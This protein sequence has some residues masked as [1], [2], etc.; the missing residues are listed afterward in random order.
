MKLI[1][2][3]TNQERY[4]IKRMNGQVM[5]ILESEMQVDTG[6]GFESPE[7]DN[8]WILDH[9][10]ISV[11]RKCIFF[12]GDYCVAVFEPFG[13]LTPSDGYYWITE[14]DLSVNKTDE[15]AALLL[16]KNADQSK[17]APWMS[18]NGLFKYL[19]WAKMSL[20]EMGYTVQGKV[21][22]IKN[23]YI[24]TIFRIPTNVSVVYLKI[25]SSVYVNNANEERQLTERFGELP[26]FLAVSPDGFAA[27]TK[28]MPGHDCSIGSTEQYERWLVSWGKKQGRTAGGNT[29]G[30]IDCSPQKLL[31]DIFD[32]EQQ[33]THILEVTKRPLSELGHKLL[34]EKLAQI[35]ISLD[36]LCHHT[37]PNT[38][39]HVDI[40]SGNVRITEDS[41][42]LYDWGMAFYGHPF[43]DLLHFLRV[44][45]RQLTEEQK[46][47][48]IDAYLS[49]W[50]PYGDKQMLQELY[51]QTE[52]CMEYFM[53]TADCRWVAEILDVC[54]GIPPKGTLDSWLLGKRL[55]YFDR[56]LHSFIEG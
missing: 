2:A 37:I 51:A 54:G 49:Q 22:Q 17:T 14:D 27:I 16:A 10:G 19:E 9:C 1:Y 13:N 45:R 44:V 33:V 46:S 40:R 5:C 39:C 53:L 3:V 35:K 34:S 24:S 25:T 47:E 4:L 7:A 28:E 50:E 11:Y 23:A 21:E 56:G 29:L 6:Y 32:F 31:S 30:L 48:I 18:E 43:Y 15:A 55:Y 38:I 8:Q 26:I 20:S 52:Q 12:S 36:L 41:E 42:I